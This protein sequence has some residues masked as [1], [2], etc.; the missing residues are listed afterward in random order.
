MGTFTIP[1]NHDSVRRLHMFE[2]HSVLRSGLR[3]IVP[4][5]VKALRS[6][7]RLENFHKSVAG[8]STQDIFEAIYA[9]RMWTGSEG[10]QYSS[11]S[12]SHDPQIVDPYVAGI[13][14][15]IHSL[16]F[17]PDAVD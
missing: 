16:N 4:G 5:P 8:G 11:G 17:R 13:S 15:I 1:G 10:E 6:R 3:K 7:R 9:Q 2:P 12:G 14:R